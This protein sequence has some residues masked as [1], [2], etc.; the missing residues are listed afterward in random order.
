V[1]EDFFH[2]QYEDEMNMISVEIIETDS[3]D[4]FEGITFSHC[5]FVQG[6]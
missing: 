3:V 1:V 2:Q 6:L 4:Q 5:Q